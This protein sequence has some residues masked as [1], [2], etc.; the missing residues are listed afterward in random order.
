[1]YVCQ[2]G[3]EVSHCMQLIER[4]TI[5]E[6]LPYDF[7]MAEFLQISTLTPKG[8]ERPNRAFL[9]LGR[10]P[11]L[12]SRPDSCEILHNPVVPRI[13]ANKTIFI[14]NT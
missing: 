3:F 10:L 1:M 8:R 14:K 4:F 13:L 2:D 11:K 7:L 5:S 9:I 12:D 6:P